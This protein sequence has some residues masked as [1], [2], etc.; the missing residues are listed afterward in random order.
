VQINRVGIGLLLFFAI[1]GALFVVVPVVLGADLMVTAILASVGIIWVLVAGGLGL[2]ARHQ[3]AKA[4]RQDQIFRTGIKGT[5]T[6]LAAG[7]HATVNEMPLMKLKLELDIP[8]VG[9]RQVSRREV[10]PV[11]TADRMAPGLVLPAYF[12][13][14]DPGDFILVW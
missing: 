10:M 2:Y 11:F 6:V 14:Q 5:A 13:A 3:R 1:F 9:K 12:D 4:A 7:S 8:G